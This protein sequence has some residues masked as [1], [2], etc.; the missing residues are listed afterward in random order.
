MI[1]GKSTACSEKTKSVLIECAYFKPEGI[2][3]KTLK[4]NIQSDAA[5]K[6]ER[7]VDINIHDFAIRRFINIINEFAIIKNIEL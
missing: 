4:Y 5:Y 7:G 3:G 1:G 2:I 6:F